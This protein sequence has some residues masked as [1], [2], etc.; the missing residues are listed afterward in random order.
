MD[1]SKIINQ[2]NQLFHNKGIKQEARFDLLIKLLEENNADNSFD[3]KF[4]DILTLINS[5]DYSN[6]DLIQ[7]MFMLLGSKFTKY[8]LDI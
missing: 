2:I 1:N 4:S 5:L 3:S 8:K 7:E 6:K